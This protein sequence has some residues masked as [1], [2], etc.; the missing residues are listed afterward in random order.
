[1]SAHKYI[2]VAFVQFWTYSIL[3]IFNKNVVSFVSR[4]AGLVLCTQALHDLR[5]PMF[6]TSV[7]YLH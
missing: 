4:S 7:P 6:G 3:L 5:V 1:M 2:E